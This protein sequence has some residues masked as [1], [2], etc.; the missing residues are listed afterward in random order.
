MLEFSSKE[1]MDRLLIELT[2]N[3]RNL[4]DSLKENLEADLKWLRQNVNALMARAAF[5]VSSNELLTKTEEFEESVKSELVE[6]SHVN[7]LLLNGLKADDVLMSGFE[8]DHVNKVA[9]SVR[10]LQE[11]LLY[12]LEKLNSQLVEGGKIE[13]PEVIDLGKLTTIEGLEEIG[14]AQ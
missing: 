3:A 12:A 14:S 10:Y 13:I 2:N 8:I 4:D 9:A 1:T 5:T 6:L 7:G 11:Q